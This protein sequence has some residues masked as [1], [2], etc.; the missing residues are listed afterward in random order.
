MHEERKYREHVKSPDL[1]RF[2]VV[3]NETRL[4]IAAKEDLSLKTRALAGKYRKQL[5]K[6]INENPGFKE[7]LHPFRI[8]L[9]SP[10]II[11]ETAWAAKRCLVGPMAAVSGAMAEL[12]GR[13]LSIYSREVVV[14]NGGNIFIRS[15]TPRKVMIF[16]GTSPF[17]EKIALEI[18]PKDIPCGICISSGMV[19]TSFSFGKADAVCVTAKSSALTGAAAT[20]IGNVVQDINTINDG[21][22]I[23]RKIKGLTGVLI[24]KDDR[25]GIIGKIKIV[26]V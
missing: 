22:E 24:I 8:P 11:R 5:E 4:L 17:S 26:P 6:F 3:D 13:E 14:E 21:L 7:A 23:A 10:K 9:F 18:D 16:A 15:R 20:A 1:V 19:G 25:M 12:V 2:E